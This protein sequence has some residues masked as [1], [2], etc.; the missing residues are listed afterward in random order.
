M[1]I[2]NIS[3][4][5]TQKYAYIYFCGSGFTCEIQ[6]SVHTNKWFFPFYDLCNKSI[7][8]LTLRS[9][10]MHFI[11]LNWMWA[12]KE[13]CLDIEFYKSNLYSPSEW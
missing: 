1:F 11:F 2:V 10:L 3:I 12:E 9:I 6:S 5:V 4:F 8:S 13:R 7:Y